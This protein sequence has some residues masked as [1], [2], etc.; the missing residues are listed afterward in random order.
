MIPAVPFDRLVNIGRRGC[1]AGINFSR[2]DGV[3]TTI[4][5]ARVADS[6]LRHVR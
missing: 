1:V 6:V 2:G 3:V 5:V 4:L